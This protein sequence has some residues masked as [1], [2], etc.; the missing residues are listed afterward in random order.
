MWHLHS[1]QNISHSTSDTRQWELPPLFW[2]LYNP[3]W[4]MGISSLLPSPTHH[5]CGPTPYVRWAHLSPAWWAD[6]EF[7]RVSDTAFPLFTSDTLVTGL[8]NTLVIIEPGAN[9]AGCYQHRCFSL[10]LLRGWVYVCFFHVQS[11]TDFDVSLMMNGWF[12]QRGNL[13]AAQIITF[14]FKY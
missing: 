6:S 12:R 11:A 3:T 4:L 2:H 1:H 5:R 8:S 13:G 14:Y 10:I 9:Y 7:T